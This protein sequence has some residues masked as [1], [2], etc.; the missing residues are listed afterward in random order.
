MENE[1]MFAYLDA[2]RKSGQT[3]M[4]GAASYLEDRFGVSKETASA[5]LSAWMK[6]FGARQA[7]GEVAKNEANWRDILDDGSIDEDDWDEDEENT[8]THDRP[9]NT[10][11]G[12]LAEHADEDEDDEENPYD[13]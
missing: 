9:D 1:E 12:Y 13:D 7:S 4:F 3:N 5:A 10:D 11:Y 2:L 8:E 6:S